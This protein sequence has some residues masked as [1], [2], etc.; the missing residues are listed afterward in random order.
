MVINMRFFQS[1][2][3][4]LQAL[5]RQEKAE[6]VTPTCPEKDILKINKDAG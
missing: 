2:I 6:L 3:L 1:V 5:H 4:S